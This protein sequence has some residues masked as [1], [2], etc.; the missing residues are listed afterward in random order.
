MA[1]DGADQTR[2]CLHVLI[3]RPDGGPPKSVLWKTDPRHHDAAFANSNP[4]DPADCR[5]RR[6]LVG[7]ARPMAHDRLASSMAVG[8]R[9]FTVAAIGHCLADNPSHDGT[10]QPTG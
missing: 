7:G 1:C 4:L 6:S 2:C 8:L 9:L 10:E 3:D 5:L